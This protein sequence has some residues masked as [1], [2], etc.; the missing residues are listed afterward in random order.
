M[1]GAGVI[2][3]TFC[4]RVNSHDVTR[5]FPQ[6]ASWEASIKCGGVMDEDCCDLV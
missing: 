1:V 4:H 3:D 2:V 5:E 6:R